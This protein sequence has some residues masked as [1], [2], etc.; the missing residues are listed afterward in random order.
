[1]TF[2]YPLGLLGLIGIPIL[3][4]IYIIKTKYTEQTVS[5][6]Y[7]WILSERFLKRRNP[8]S[9]ITGLI[10]LI[11]QILAIALISFAIAHPMITV[12]G[13]ANEYVFVLDAS[14][15]MTME[16]NGKS[17]F[18]LGKEV[19]ANQIE[20]AANGSRF[21]LIYAGSETVV[22]FEEL[23]DKEDALMLLDELKPGYSEDTVQKAVQ[24]AQTYFNERPSLLTY[25]ITDTEHNVNENITLVNVAGNEQN[26]AI[27]NVTHDFAGGTLSVMGDLI[28]YSV[29]E[30]LEVAM[31]IDGSEEPAAT[32]TVVVNRGEPARFQLSC[33]AE[34]FASLRVVATTYDNMSLDDEVYIY[35][36]KSDSAYNVLLV[37]DRPFFLKS[38]L[39][40]LGYT[41]MTVVSSDAFEIEMEGEASGYGLYIFDSFM[42]QSVPNDGAVWAVN[43]TSNANNAG[44]S[45][46][47]T[48]ELNGSGRLE[49]AKTTSS[50]YR[51]LAQDLQGDA[52][53]ICAYAKLGLYRNFTTVYSYN[54]TPVIFAGT[55]DFGNREVVFAFDLHNT[56]LPLVS[57]FV[58]LINNCLTYSFPNIVEKSN[59]YVGESAQINMLSNCD[60]IRV[61]SPLG[62]ISYLDTNTAVN[63]VLLNEV[64]TYTIT[65]MVEGTP[66]NFKIYAAMPEAEREPVAP[67]GEISVFGQAVP[68]GFDGEYD[69]LLILFI[70]LACIFALEWGVYCYEKRQLR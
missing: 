63:D 20:D 38:V 23:R 1:M 47:T 69:P 56:N 43:P 18:E 51:A 61:E 39:G 6:T 30:V 62:G 66:R 14:G 5:S 7:L 19:I 64:G 55:N 65:A 25:L 35:D 33:E 36:V 27:T 11:L 24:V 44:F 8:F 45:F 34:S 70:T 67:A 40:A 16:Q 12:P 54:G 13:A 60:S 21:S 41:N 26:C 37:S 31:Y 52:M 2:L 15:S 3:I 53:Y 58:I 42:P 17:R 59:Y 10:S 49:L 50:M 68:G 29:G 46:Q 4:I 22:I 32:N 48:V 9:R 28:T 57:D